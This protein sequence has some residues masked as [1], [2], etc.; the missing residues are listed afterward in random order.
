[1]TGR[2]QEGN[3]PAGL[4]MFARYAFPPNE[5]GY[6]GPDDHGYGL[7]NAA[8]ATPDD[9]ANL[10]QKF[11]GAWPYL[12]FIA[13]ETGNR[14]PL[15]RSVTE[16]YWLGFGVIDD[17]DLAAN[18]AALIGRLG[19]QAGWTLDHL[20][21]AIDAGARPHHGFHVFEVYPWTG[22]LSTGRPEPL[23]I[24]DQ[25]RIR[26]G[27]VVSVDTDTVVVR[28]RPLTWDGDT[29]GLGSPR[30]ESVRLEEGGL[31]L[32]TIPEP[33]E[34]VALHWDWLCDRLSPTHLDALRR[35]TRRQLETTNRRFG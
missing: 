34:W 11:S 9:V 30:L 12:E 5:R 6:C 10:A 21:G 19:P 18:G 15:D 3:E 20:D 24:L 4:A 1:M 25:C 31:S 2:N 13:G 33:G 17:I 27:R 22:L 14:D 26:W 35:S 23:R 16:A 29:L 28:S 32:R 8:T 7:R